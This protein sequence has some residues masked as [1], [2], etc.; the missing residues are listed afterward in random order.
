MPVIIVVISAILIYRFNDYNL[1]INAIWSSWLLEIKALLL[2][3]MHKY[4]NNNNEGMRNQLTNNKT[5]FPHISFSCLLIFL[6]GIINNGTF[7]GWC[8]ADVHNYT[9]VKMSSCFFFLFFFVFACISV[10][11]YFHRYRTMFGSYICLF[12]FCCCC[13]EGLIKHPRF[14]KSHGIF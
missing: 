8:V 5:S 6:Y 3:C 7:T 14:A 10:I 11:L 4:N 2:I 1:L 9:Y 12:Y 13:V